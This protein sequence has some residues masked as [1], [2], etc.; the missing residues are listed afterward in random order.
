[1]NVTFSARQRWRLEGAAG[2]AAEADS[3]AEAGTADEE[4]GAANCE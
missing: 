3:V 1:M 2:A 4:E